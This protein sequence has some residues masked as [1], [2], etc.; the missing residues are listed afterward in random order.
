[1][2]ARLSSFVTERGIVYTFNLDAQLCATYVPPFGSKGVSYV[3]LHE[4]GKRVV[5]GVYR[6]YDA[7]VDE[8]QI[9]ERAVVRWITSC[10]AA[11]K[12]DTTRVKDDHVRW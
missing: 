5:S 10:G 2:M 9:A 11:L 7:T 6:K 4:K 1:M 8:W 12:I 3:A